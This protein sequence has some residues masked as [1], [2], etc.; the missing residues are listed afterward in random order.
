MVM[1]SI[2]P[3]AK[4]YGSARS[5]LADHLHRTPLFS[6]TLLGKRVGA[7]LYLKC[8]N[9]QKTGSFKV[10]GALHKLVT[11]DEASRRRGVVT[12]S[13]GNFAQAL[14]W[15]AREAS[16]P[17]V[18]VMPAGASEAKAAASRGYGAEVILH[19]TVVEAFQHARDL[20]AE[21]RLTFI[22]P[23]DDIDI[24]TGHAS[25]GLEILEQARDVTAIVVP[26]GGG[27]L[28]A[29]IAGVLKLARPDVR[30]YGVEPEGA[31]AMRKSLDAGHAVHIDNIDT[32]A[33][34]L[35]PPMAGELTFEFV[36]EYVEDIVTVSDGEI[37]EAMG[38]LLGRAKV[39][40]EPAGAAG[41]AALLSGCI[42]LEAGDRVVAVLSG[43]NVALADLQQ[44][45]CKWTD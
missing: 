22:H 37:V 15:A 14:A 43:G 29:G 8:E 41:M 3:S 21:R 20:E 32:I 25:V 26:V 1:P 39:L 30:I 6:A 36:K 38:V 31:C 44:F 4:A 13:A 19:G 45:A 42:P 23:F 12:I 16:V 34:G 5:L 40:T 17:C 33:D 35:A 7:E 27:G 18:V 2:S 24:I 9:L 11:L 10:R 28:I